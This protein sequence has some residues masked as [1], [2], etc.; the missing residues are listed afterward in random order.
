MLQLCYDGTCWLDTLTV[1]CHGSSTAQRR[2]LSQVKLE[3]AD[4]LS[5][6]QMLRDEAGKSGEFG[7]YRQGPAGTIDKSFCSGSTRHDD[8]G[9]FSISHQVP[10]CKRRILR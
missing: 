10:I 7:G 8:Q 9:P 3:R 5:A 4:L 6:L 2:Q 1:Y